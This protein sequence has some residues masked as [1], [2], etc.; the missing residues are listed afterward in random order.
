[1][2]KLVTSVSQGVPHVLS[3]VPLGCPI[4]TDLLK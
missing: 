3:P 1:M 2:E 4:S